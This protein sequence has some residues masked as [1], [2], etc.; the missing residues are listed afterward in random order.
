MDIGTCAV[1]DELVLHRNSKMVQVTDTFASKCLQ[2]LKPKMLS[3]PQ[4]LVNYYDI[5]RKIA[6][7]KGAMLSPRSEVVVSVEGELPSIRV[8]VSCHGSLNRPSKRDLPPEFAIAN[9]F[10]IGE[11]PLHL[12]D[13]TLP[14]L[15]LTSLASC[16]PPIFVVRGGKHRAIRSHVMVFDSDAMEINQKL[17]RVAKDEAKLLVI[18]TNPVTTVQEKITRRRFQVRR[19]MLKDLLRHWNTNHAS[20]DANISKDSLWNIQRLEQLALSPL[21]VENFVVFHKQ[22]EGL[23][24][25]EPVAQDGSSSGKNC[26]D[27]EH[28][29]DEHLL[30]QHSSI[31]IEDQDTASIEALQFAALKVVDIQRYGKLLPDRTPDFFAR[32]FPEL[33]PYGQGH[34][35]SPRS[36][37]VAMQKCCAHYIRLSGR[38]FAQHPWFSL[39]AFDSISRKRAIESTSISCTINP[40]DNAKISAVTPEQLSEQLDAIASYRSSLRKGIERSVY[41]SGNPANVLLRKVEAA[42]GHAYATN[43]ERKKYQRMAWNMS[44]KH[45]GAAI[46]ATLTPNENGSATVIYYAGEMGVNS[47]RNVSLSDVPKHAHR[48][49]ISGKDPHAC[50]LF[51]TNMLDLFFETILGFDRKTKHPY[52]QGGSFGTVKAFFGGIESQTKQTLHIHSI[53][54]LAGLP[55]TVD[56]FEKLCESVEFREKLSTFVD[57]IISSKTCVDGQQQ[58]CTFCQGDESIEAVK[59]INQKAFQQATRGARPPATSECVRCGAVYGS[60]DILRAV[61]CNMSEEL[62]RAGHGHGQIPIFDDLTESDIQTIHHVSLPIIS[63]RPTNA[64]SDTETKKFILR[65][66]QL[67]LACQRHNWRHARSCFKTSSNAPNGDCRYNFPRPAVKK[68]RF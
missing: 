35:G 3:L 34:P 27:D 8:C 11:L 62:H 42:T 6:M 67:T 36:V 31:L 9:G 46:F 66:L 64:S 7:L 48:I 55:R 33:F 59:N 22:E 32:L 63:S 56:E 21:G 23:E 14:E 12:K 41:P 57:S 39:V 50:D 30:H 26:K 47:L 16:S 40:R 53:I 1:C 24:S 20:Y 37:P 29:S 54:F 25:E 58:K 10:A 28:S 51:F 68:Q 18:L 38:H 61:I 43:E 13:A 44:A 45:H 15:W 60:D 4:Q 5:S 49:E 17:D 2:Q 65:S 52:R 19:N